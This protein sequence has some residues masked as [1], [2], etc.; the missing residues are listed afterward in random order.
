MVHQNVSKESAVVH[1]KVYGEKRSTK[2]DEC[3]NDLN[4]ECFK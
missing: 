4:V 3:Q 1:Q 2:Y